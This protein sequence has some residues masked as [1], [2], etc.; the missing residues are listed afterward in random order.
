MATVVIDPGHGG[1]E[2]VGGSSPNNA[3][4]PSGTK[5]KTLTLDIGLKARNFLRLQGVAVI[6]T[7]DSD[8]NVG[9]ADRVL[10]AKRA[11][12]HA[13]L[14]IHFNG[15]M[16]PAVQ[17]TETWISNTENGDSASAKLAQTVQE[18]VVAVTG[19][20]NRGVKAESPDPSG[21]LDPLNHHFET[22]I[23]LVEISFLTNP[24][25]EARLTNVAL[26]EQYK[27]LLAEAISFAVFD[28]LRTRGFL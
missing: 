7:R 15:N 17:G 14:S 2:M 21:V 28:N 26:G 27:M 19:Y 16:N 6:M 22:A 4:G 11:A 23:S 24:E 18:K 12:A 10:V 25:D 1:T 8:I 9:I 20:R 5:E 3:T 13:F